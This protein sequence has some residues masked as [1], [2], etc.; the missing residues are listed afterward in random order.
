M[1]T[2]RKRKSKPIEYVE[3]INGCH[4]CTSHSCT[5]DGYP[6]IT[7]L[8]RLQRISRILYEKHNGQIPD[9]MV[10]RHTCDNP[11]CINLAHLIIG[12]HADNVADRVLRGRSAVGVRN[13]RS[14][15]NEQQVQQILGSTASHCSLSRQFGVSE[16]TIRLI[17]QGRN[18]ASVPRQ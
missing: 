15:L 12:T 3:N 11:G 17:R 4:I 18:W 1:A 9:G 10:L 14:K 8:G 7:L 16:K 6:R 13:G 5:T 2:V